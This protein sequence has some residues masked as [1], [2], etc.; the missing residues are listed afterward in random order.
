[1]EEPRQAAAPGRIAGVYQRLRPHWALLLVLVAQSAIVLSLR[2][3]AFVDEGC[4]LFSGHTE[5]AQ[6]FGGPTPDTDYATYFSGSPYLYPMIAAI[7]NALGGLGA[8]RGLSLICMLGATVM[9]YRATTLLFGRRAAFY[10]AGLFALCGPSLFMSHLATFDAPSVLLLASAFWY[11]IRCAD[12][13]V[14]MLETIGLAVLAIAFKYAAIAYAIPIVLTVGI[15][16]IPRVGWRW[17][18][19]RT[20]VVGSLVML[21]AFG[22]LCIAGPTSLAGLTSTTL[23]RPPATNTVDQIAQRSAVYVGFVLVLAAFGTLWFV[24]KRRQQPETNTPVESE[25]STWNWKVRALLALVLTGSALIA[26][27]GDM[28]LHTLTSLEKHAGYGLLFAAPMA[29]W[30]L[31]RIA[32]RRVWRT[33]PAVAAV[34]ALGAFGANQAHE[35]FGEWLTS[36]AYVHE[37]EAVTAKEPNGAH[38]L[39]E[40]PWV[41]RYYLGDGGSR[42]VWNDTY[43]FTFTS[44]TGKQL[45]GLPAYQAAITERYFSVVEIDYNGTPGIDLQLDQVLATSGYERVSVPSFYRYGQVDVE[46]WTA[47]G[48]AN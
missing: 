2:N 12:N 17:A 22:L 44:N 7:A 43:S 3:S 28:R 26:P 27:I 8:A 39:A 18:T 33:I 16:A 41:A 47:I 9:L 29:G 48:G 38:V 23:N 32:G 42:F 40:D 20:V 35:F 4:Y 31:S 15:C 37:L 34:A 10:A 46:I 36:T 6:L 25:V 13:K 21:L 45:T 30:L 11:A 1:L 19:A 14:Y 24:I 5:W